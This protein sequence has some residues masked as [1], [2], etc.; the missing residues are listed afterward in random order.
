MRLPSAADLDAV[1]EEMLVKAMT[2]G[3][4]PTVSSDTAASDE[5]RE[6][7]DSAPHNS[8]KENQ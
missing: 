2:S 3:A 8:E 1:M 4:A 7:T 6:I 5:G